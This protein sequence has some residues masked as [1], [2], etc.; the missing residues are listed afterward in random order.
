LKPLITVLDERLKA[1]GYCLLNLPLIPAPG[2][3]MY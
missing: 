3:S 2:F 1:Q